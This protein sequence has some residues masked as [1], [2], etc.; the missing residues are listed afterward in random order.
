M[1]RREAI[2][3]K[4]EELRKEYREEVSFNKSAWEQYGSELCVGEMVSKEEGILKEIRHLEEFLKMPELDMDDKT[5]KQR[6]KE[7][8][9][10]IDTQRG[11]V[12]ERHHEVQQLSNYLDL[13]AEI[14][15]G[16]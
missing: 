5:L 1:T 6:R 9:V 3:K 14:H 4:I 10:R 15:E 8:S 13:L 12:F 7:I 11:K 2:Q 16:T